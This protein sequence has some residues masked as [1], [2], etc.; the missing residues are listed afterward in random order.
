MIYSPGG[1]D[2]SF[3]KLLV[4]QFLLTLVLAFLVAWILGVTAAGT[5]YGQRVMMVAVIAAFGAIIV[6]GQYWNWYEFPTN[7]TVAYALGIFIC[8]ALAGVVM[9]SLVGK[10][11]KTQSA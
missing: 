1:T 3:G 7:Y 10:R 9:A 4:N 6:P 8:W 11:A 5:T 2:F